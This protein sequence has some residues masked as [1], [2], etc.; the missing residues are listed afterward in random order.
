LQSLDLLRL[1]AARDVKR[2]E[3]IE[4]DIFQ[5]LVLFAISEIEILRHVDF[6]DVNRGRLI[7]DANEPVGLLVWEG[8]EEDAFHYAEDHCVGAYT[9]SHSDENDGREKWRAAKPPEDLLELANK[10]RHMKSPERL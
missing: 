3:A 10:G 4:T 8:F 5:G 6:W 1:S 2:Q 9:D 7:P